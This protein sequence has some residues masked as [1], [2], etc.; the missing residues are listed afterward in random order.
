MRRIDLTGHRYGRWTVLEL[1]ATQTPKKTFW[2][3]RCDCGTVKDV[4]ANSMRT[5]HS[6]SCGCYDREVAAKRMTTHGDSVGK[7]RAPE[8]INWYHMISRCYNKNRRDYMNYGGRGI[9]VC[10]QW[11]GDSGYQNFLS[12]IGRRPTKDHTIDRID[13]NGNYEPEN[14]RWATRQQQGI[15][16]RLFKS[17]TSGCPGVWFYNL[18]NKWIAKITVNYKQIHLGYFEDVFEAICAR[19]SAELKY[20]VAL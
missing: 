11:R 17:N 7:K 13:V 15:N 10:D 18:R 9:S 8:M 5:G 1:S 19:K 20:G 16:R 3:C 12:Y 2:T 6:K 14:V 4:S